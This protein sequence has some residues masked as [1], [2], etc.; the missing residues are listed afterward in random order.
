MEFVVD[1]VVMCVYTVV[2]VVA[3]GVVVSV[4]ANNR[5]ARGNA[6]SREMQRRVSGRVKWHYVRKG[7]HVILYFD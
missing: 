7:Y 4:G 2:H 1:Q 6:L 5:G 3:H